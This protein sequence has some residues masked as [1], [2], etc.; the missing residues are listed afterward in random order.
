MTSLVSL[1]CHVPCFQVGHGNTR[2]ITDL[3][4]DIGTTTELVDIGTTT[5]LVVNIRTRANL[6][7]DNRTTPTSW[8][9]ETKQNF[10]LHSITG[11]TATSRSY[12]KSVACRDQAQTNG[13]QATVVHT[14]YKE[15]DTSC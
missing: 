4:V 3:V 2:A 12:L 7:V 9:G 13:L 15:K 8:R 10:D 14:R 1:P 6:V 5:E 11:M